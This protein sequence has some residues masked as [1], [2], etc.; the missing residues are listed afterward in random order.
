M[1]GR[2]GHAQARVHLAEVALLDAEEVPLQAGRV[3]HAAELLAALQMIFGL[4]VAAE[5]A[6]GAAGQEPGGGVAGPRSR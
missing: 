5:A 6:G 1:V 2:D 3:G 4:G